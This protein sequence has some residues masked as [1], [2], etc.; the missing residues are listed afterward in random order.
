MATLAFL[1][2]LVGRDP[3]GRRI[4]ATFSPL[5]HQV[6]W[7]GK[8]TDELVRKAN[9]AINLVSAHTTHA[10][11][12]EVGRYMHSSPAMQ[13]HHIHAFDGILLKNFAIAIFTWGS[14]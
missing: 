2:K 7:L 9:N 5:V 10:P 6:P 4:D 3:P 8:R 11:I 14:L 1:A 13:C 12:I